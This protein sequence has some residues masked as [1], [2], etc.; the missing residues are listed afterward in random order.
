MK[1]LEVWMKW[2]IL[3]VSLFSFLKIQF[4]NLMLELMKTFYLNQSFSTLFSLLS[5]QGAFLD[6]FFPN[7]PPH[8]I[9]IP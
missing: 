4:L 3:Y 5:S 8:N 1:F 7:H 2:Q 6:I 9:L